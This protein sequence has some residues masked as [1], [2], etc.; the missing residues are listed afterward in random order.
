MTTGRE[1]VP[2]DPELFRGLIDPATPTARV[3]HFLRAAAEFTARPRED[4][5]V[6][7]T[8]TFTESSPA[9]AALRRTG[10]V[11]TGAKPGRCPSASQGII[12]VRQRLLPLDVEALHRIHNQVRRILTA[13]L[14]VQHLLQMFHA[15]EHD[16]LPV[17]AVDGV[18]LEVG[19]VVGLLRRHH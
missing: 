2:A 19:R 6:R 8:L 5:R 17:L 13:L 3:D 16:D 9:L 15:K 18:P 11:R 4:G 1:S 10:P 7:T 12:S 14:H